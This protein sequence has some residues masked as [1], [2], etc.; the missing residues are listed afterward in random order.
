FTSDAR[1]LEYVQ[2]DRSRVDRIVKRVAGH[3]EWGVRVVLTP[4]EHKG[5]APASRRAGRTDPGRSKTG[6]AYLAAKKQQRDHSTELQRHAR[7]TVATLYDRLEDRAARAKRRAASELPVQG[8]PLLLDAAFLV[9][10][11]A[12]RGF[13]SFVER[14]S[15]TLAAQGYRV[16]A[17]GPWPPYSF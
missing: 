2:S 8:G 10:R 1:A 5:R 17:S 3:V 6:L 7:E 11:A 12:S 15:K 13:R 16:T 14:Q 9:R 4:T